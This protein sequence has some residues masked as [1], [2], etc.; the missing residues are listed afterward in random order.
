MRRIGENT[1]KRI[2]YDRNKDRYIDYNTDTSDNPTP[3]VLQEAI[4]EQPIRVQA[5]IPQLRRSQRVRS[6]PPR[7]GDYIAY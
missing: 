3:P 2:T 7:Y 5:P 4:I 6:V 1:P